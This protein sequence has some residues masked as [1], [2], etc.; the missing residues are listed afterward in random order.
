LS[1]SSEFERIA[2]YVL[3]H[4]ERWDG[5]GYPRGLRG[6]EISIQARIITLADSYDVMKSERS[7]CNNRSDNEAVI[8]IKKCAG[9]QFD[10]NLSKLF[11]EKILKKIW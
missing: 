1:S 5:K 6:E 4:H 9:A 10:P 11:V 2:E 3:E 7:Y 8:E